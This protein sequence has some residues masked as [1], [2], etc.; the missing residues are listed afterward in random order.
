MWKIPET[1]LQFFIFYILLT[2]VSATLPSNKL[3]NYQKF[4]LIEKQ[5]LNAVRVSSLQFE[6]FMY[7][8]QSGQFYDGIEYK[9][10]E[11]F[12]KKGHLQLIFEDRCNPGHSTIQYVA[13]WHCIDPILFNQS[14]LCRSA[15]IV[16]G[17]IFPNATF[18]TV[19]KLSRPYVQDDLIWCIQTAKYYPWILNILFAATPECWLTL[20][21]GVGYISGTVIYIMIQFDLKYK[22]R[23]QRDWH[24]T[25]WL[26]ALPAVIAIN[27]RFRPVYGPLR[28]FYA[29]LL[30]TMF[31][32][33]Q[34]V[35]FFGIRFI[36][37]PI[38][39]PQ[40]STVQEI[41]DEEFRLSGSNEVLQLLSSDRKVAFKI[42]KT[43]NLS[44]KWSKLCL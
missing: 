28:W 17:G 20:I 8:N 16:V 11:T 31:F 7:Q 44:R 9:L 36:K 41:I 39:R 10:L 30:I 23:N 43:F 4:N 38:Q 32:L 6:P 21:F 42:F 15:D 27:Q 1:P 29:L 5:P 2:S 35:F 3:K 40:I 34:I 24:Y 19:F 12:A 13:S 18:S 25:T 33:W 26:V 37:Y 14:N 22:H